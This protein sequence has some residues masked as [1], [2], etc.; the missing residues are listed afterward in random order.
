MTKAIIYKEWIKL[1]WVMISIGAVFMASLPYFF[2][3]IENKFRFAGKAHLWSVIAQK[4]MNFIGEL[5]YLPLLSGII[6]G[7]FQFIPEMN[8]KSFKLTLHLPHPE[9]LIVLK[10]MLF[11]A[12]YL[13]SVFLLTIIGLLT[14]LS[15]SLPIVVIQAWIMAALPWFM[16]GIAAYFLSAWICIEPSWKQR[17]INMVLAGVVLALFFKGGSSYAYL[18][19]W[20]SL[21]IISVVGILF[22]FYSV[23]RFKEGV[24]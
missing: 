3:N 14:I 7:L 6:L 23:S 20:S 11:S 5:T 13:L 18:Y 10:M 9:R 24:Q 1:R 8:K 17:A 4:D 2:L 22:P 12:L 21:M 19:G 15:V 16:A